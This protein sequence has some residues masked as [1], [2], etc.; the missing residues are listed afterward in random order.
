MSK[1]LNELWEDAKIRDFLEKED[2]KKSHK[3]LFTI[4]GVCG[5]IALIAGVAIFLYK[6]F[7]P[8]YFDDFDDE[9]DDDDDDM[10]E[11]DIFDDDE[12]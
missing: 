12:K 2:E 7:A 4:L 6:Y 3:K 11:E 1:K 5:I 10:D 8:D 9:F